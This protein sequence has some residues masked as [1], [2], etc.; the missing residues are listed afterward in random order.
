MVSDET[1]FCSMIPFIDQDAADTFEQV[2]DLRMGPVEALAQFSMFSEVM[3]ASVSN[4]QNN[5]FADLRTQ[6]RS[7]S[8]T[9][10]CR[11]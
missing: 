2:M 4:Q 5:S 9:L 6:R 7:N 10:L 8:M 3:S 1:Y 11:S